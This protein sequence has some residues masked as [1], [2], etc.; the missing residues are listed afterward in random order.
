MS[1]RPQ[2]AVEY[3]TYLGSL[4]LRKISCFRVS[5]FDLL[6]DK[7]KFKLAILKHLMWQCFLDACGYRQRAKWFLYSLPLIQDAS[8][9][10][11]TS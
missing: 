1:I 9:R 8:L 2:V 3:I 4:I 6:N 11:E 7:I 5:C 10:I